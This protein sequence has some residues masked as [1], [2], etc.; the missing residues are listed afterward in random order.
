M[1]GLILKLKC[2]YFDHLMQRADRL[3]KTLMLEKTEGRKNRMTEDEMLGWSLP[4][5]VN[6]LEQIPGVSV[7][8]GS[9][10][11]FSPWAHKESDSTEGLNNNNGPNHPWT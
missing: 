11:S 2:Q 6:E 8:W 1:E 3:E 7:R 10:V 5:N 9:L 4:F